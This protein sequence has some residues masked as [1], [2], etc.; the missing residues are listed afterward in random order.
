MNPAALIP[1]PGAIQVPW[2]WFEFLL[3]L[4]FILHLLL[5]NALVGG[6]VIC[7]VKTLRGQG[8]SAAVHDH[9]LRLP[10][11]LALTVN[12]GVAPLLFVQV[13]YGSFIYSSSI[14]IAWWWLAVIGIIIAAYYGLYV[15]DFRFQRLGN[16]GRLFLI[17]GP[18]LLLLFTAFI[19]VNNMTL[20]ATPDRWFAYFKTPDGTLLNL[21]EPTL[22]PRY[23]HF[24]VAALAIGGLAQALVWERKRCKGAADEAQ[25]AEHVASGLRWFFRA[26][27]AQL[28]IGAWFLFSL[29]RY[30]YMNFLGKEQLDTLLLGVGLVLTLASLHFARKGRVW[31]TVWTAVAT[32]AVMA[33]LRD[34]LRQAYLRPYFTPGDLQ[35]AAQYSPLVLFAVSLVIGLALVGYML[36]LWLKANREGE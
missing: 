27:L 32:V 12:L 34:L 9:A 13:L 4:T 14:L 25:A 10:T 8:G 20:A 18:T 7:T 11:L 3:L 36:K 33:G 15:Y 22:A 21:G 28:A 6:A 16:G 23:L 35:V 29:P 31:P 30:L 2:G 5:M 26:T 19:Y 17:L 24:M 1:T